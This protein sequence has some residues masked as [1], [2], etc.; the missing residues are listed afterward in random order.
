M[1]ELKLLYPGDEVEL[2]VQSL[3]DAA[4]HLVAASET[5]KRLL[6]VSGG[7]D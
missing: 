2:K 6:D 5:K 1:Y 7:Y 3:D 4:T